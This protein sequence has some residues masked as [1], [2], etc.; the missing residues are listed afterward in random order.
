[1]A[2][3]YVAVVLQFSKAGT[4]DGASPTNHRRSQPERGASLGS[5]LLR[6]KLIQP[7]PGQVGR[8]VAGLADDGEMG[9]RTR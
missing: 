7:D 6:E 3:R 5:A 9:L 2:E 4:E 8:V 1:M